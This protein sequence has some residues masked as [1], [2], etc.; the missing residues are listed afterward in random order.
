[1]DA[2][3]STLKDNNFKVCEASLSF[4]C[5][6]LEHVDAKIFQPYFNDYVNLLMERF[7]DS[8]TSVRDKAFEA[9][10]QIGKHFTAK[11]TLEAIREGFIH[12]S[13]KVR[14][15]VCMSFVEVLQHFGPKSIPLNRFLPDIVSLLDDSTA[16]VRDAAVTAVCEIYRYVGVDLI[17][18]LGTY[19]IRVAQMKSIE[20]RASEIEVD[21]EN[22]VSLKP[23]NL[24]SPLKPKARHTIH[25]ISTASNGK[26]NSTVD[27][28]ND[29]VDVQPAYIKENDLP[30]EIEAINETLQDVR[31]GDWKKRL[32]AIRRLRGL[33]YGGVTDFSTF[34]SEFSRLKD[35]ISKQVV[36]LRST[37]VKE[38]CILLNLL[39][40]TL[41][42]R[43]ELFS[44]YFVPILLKSTV[45]T[46]QV[47]SDS[48][49]NCIRTL[50]IHGK[51]NKG[52]SLLTERIC[53]S[54]THVTMRGRCA[55]YLVLVLQHVDYSIL[56]KTMDEL[57]KAIKASVTDASAAARQAG[58][59]AFVIFKD[60]FP[61]RANR[62]F[63]ELDPSTQKK[64]TGDKNGQISPRGSTASSM[65]I[66]SMASATSSVSSAVSSTSSIRRTRSA[67]P[68]KIGKMSEEVEI[69]SKK[70]V[71]PSVP[72]TTTYPSSPKKNLSIK[73]QPGKKTQSTSPISPSSPS[74]PKTAPQPLRSSMQISKLDVSTNSDPMDTSGDLDVSMESVNAIV[75]ESRSL[76]WK[77]KVQVFEKMEIILD[78]SRISEVKS[79]FLPVINLYID[80]LSDSNQNV[81]DKALSSSM[82]LIEKLPECVEPYLERILSKLF[83]LL[84]EDN[85]KI[86]SEKLLTKIGN[87]YSGDIL[88]PRL[89]K[90]VDTYNSRIRVAC[91]EFLMHIVQS[92]SA[93]LSFPAHMKSSIKKTISLFQQ[94]TSKTCEPVLTSIMVSLYTVQPKVFLEQILSLPSVEQNP[95]KNILRENVPDFD[96]N[97]SS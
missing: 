73:V 55:E 24:K 10:I 75:R 93:Y 81:V 12:K 62:L 4:L 8:K 21:V 23:K 35:A 1:M 86:L 59:Q 56:S 15:G 64:L 78:S 41:G 11:D 57:T 61:E 19:K 97:L 85:T 96:N 69:V 74:K 30:R 65:S 70:T 72:M 60:S 43:F 50:I 79:T 33:T 53:D 22:L 42:S 92:S 3:R 37:I 20:D 90:I 46:V 48:V 52:V 58:R 29:D 95:I 38:A 80:R 2:L 32:N 14:E 68:R 25:T 28:E 47:I 94:N 34:T 76:D 54:K 71:K 88:L 82:K 36:D 16:S 67:I 7:G 87:S 89:F 45:V 77:T 26:T 83:L 27:C 17:Q 91:L 66:H 49:N 51:L 18:E 13:W 84:T 39:A 5:A 44:D 31:N 9:I 6:F 40:K 63:M